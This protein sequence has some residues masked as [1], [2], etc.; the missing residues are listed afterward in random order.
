MENHIKS[1][2]DYKIY[3]CEFCDKKFLVKWRMEKHVQ[4]HIK[5]TKYCHYHNNEK[6]CAYND[7]GCKFKHED[8]N[9]CRFGNTCRFKLCQYKHTVNTKKAENDEVHKLNTSEDDRSNQQ[10]K[11]NSFKCDPPL[12]MGDGKA[13]VHRSTI[14]SCF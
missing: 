3:G 13:T 1:H 9:Q 2:K 4:C 14:F 12:H 8:S 6:H 5:Q 11:R 10:G 7:I